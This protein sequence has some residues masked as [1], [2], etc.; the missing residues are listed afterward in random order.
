MRVKGEHYEVVYDD[1]TS[2]IVCTGKMDLRGKE[3]YMPIAKLFEDVIEKK[4]A[5]ITLDI[6]NLRYLN[7]S[8]IT[9]IGAGLII[10]ARKK[11]GIGIVVHSTKEYSWQ[12]RSMKGIVKLMPGLEVKID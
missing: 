8:G 9:T 1:S 5:T 4:P 3:G 2:S 12:Y 11:G 10:K 7:S 6:R